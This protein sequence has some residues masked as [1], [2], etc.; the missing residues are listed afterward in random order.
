MDAI[1]RSLNQMRAS[2]NAPQTGRRGSDPLSLSS[3]KS[4]LRL[5]PSDSPSAPSRTTVFGGTDPLP[6]S[7]F[8]KEIRE[9]K[10]GDEPSAMKRVFVKMYEYPELG[11]RLKQLRPDEKDKGE[12]WFSIEELN[13][14]L[15]RLR[16]LE[17]KE[18]EPKIYG[19][20]YKDFRSGLEMLKRSD[21]EKK[22][23][24]LQ[25]HGI[26]GL[27]SRTPEFMLQPPKEHLVEKY[28]HPDNMSSAEKMKLELAKV[29]D[30]FKLSESDCGSARVQVAQ[31]T[32]KIKHLSAVLHKKDKHSRKGLVGMVQRRKRLLKYLRRTD[33]DSYCFVLDKLGLRDNPDYKN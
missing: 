23:A 13:Q 21:D 11:E 33:W 1:R 6:Q 19:M 32:T 26:L 8:G 17:E 24:N 14:R 29:R 20:Q 4:S 31:L 28:F 22:K 10:D 25:K 27:M 16:E 15:T 2:N 9:R 7:V 18:T 5:R 30:E 3:F 12:G